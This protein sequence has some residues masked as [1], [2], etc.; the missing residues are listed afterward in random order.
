MLLLFSAGLLA[1][2]ATLRYWI[3][4]CPRNSHLDCRP[5][6]AELAQWALEAWQSASNG[7]L[8]LEQTRDREAAHIRVLWADAQSGLYGE[9]N[10]IVV[11]GVRGA[12]VYVAPAAA[13][14]ADPDP[15]GLQHTRAFD[16]I[17]YDFRYGG[18]IENYFQRYRR[19]LTTRAAIR[20]HSGISPGDLRQLHNLWK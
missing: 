10:P 12:E 20:K 9:A 3:E 18:D 19:L 13:R 14:T 4:D 15:L 6:D 5:E 16:D 11:E 7:A 8:H 1:H 17:M 2:A